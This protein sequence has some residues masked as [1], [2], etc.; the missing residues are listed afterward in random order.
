VSGSSA[1]AGRAK[2][3]MSSKNARRRPENR[4]PLAMMR[5]HLHRDFPDQGSSLA[6]VSRRLY[7]NVH[8]ISRPGPSQESSRRMQPTTHVM[9][10]KFRY[11]VSDQPAYGHYHGAYLTDALPAAM[12]TCLGPH[13]CTFQMPFSSLGWPWEHR[14]QTAGTSWSDRAVQP[15]MP[16]DLPAKVRPWE[17][18][19]YPRQRRTL[20]LIISSRTSARCSS[21]VST[22]KA[23]SS[24]AKSETFAEPTTGKPVALTCLV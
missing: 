3:T 8:R 21:I 9:S 24:S 19:V 10:G 13:S 2:A 5:P 22:R 1:R 15:I 14:G 4:F 7:T 6:L 12:D 20:F 23:A 16:L 11:E 18:A 17:L